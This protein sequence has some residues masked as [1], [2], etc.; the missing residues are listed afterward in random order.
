M[1]KL[2]LPESSLVYVDTVVII[3]RGCTIFLTND[4]GL[5]NISGLSVVV[6][7]DLLGE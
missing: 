4:A 2:T 7:N 6:L 1:G 3:Y 5:R